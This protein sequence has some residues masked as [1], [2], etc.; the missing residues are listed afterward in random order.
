MQKRQF[1]DRQHR[2][3]AVVEILAG[4]YW[5][6]MPPI[7]GAR[8]W[9]TIPRADAEGRRASHRVNFRPWVS[10]R[11]T[12]SARAIRVGKGHCPSARP[13]RRRADGG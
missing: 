3:K 11:A 2:N 6:S 10:A 13:P 8:I 7:G 12:P 4:I 5:A 1:Y 9:E